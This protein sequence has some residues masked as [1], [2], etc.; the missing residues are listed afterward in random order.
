MAI[1]GSYPHVLSATHL[2]FLPLKVGHLSPAI[3]F[4]PH[5][6]E[7]SVY[8]HEYLVLA[9]QSALIEIRLHGSLGTT[10][11][12]VLFLYFSSTIVLVL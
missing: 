5:V 3:T 7:L 9:A 8:S 6:L 4:G 1:L 11:G 10:T 12:G 2:S